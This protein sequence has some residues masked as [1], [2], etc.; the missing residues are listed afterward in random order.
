VSSIRQVKG[1]LAPVFLSPSPRAVP[2]RSE[3]L[4]S[5][6]IPLPSVSQGLPSWS[7]VHDTSERGNA[8]VLELSLIH[9][10]TTAGSQADM[11]LGRAPSVYVCTM[12]EGRQSTLSRTWMEDRCAG[13]CH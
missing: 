13:W 4:V 7:W 9:P 12:A 2:G 5:A 8:G 6:P 1:D 10:I 11:H 3:R